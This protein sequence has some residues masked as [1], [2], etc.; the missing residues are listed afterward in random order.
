MQRILSQYAGPGWASRLGQYQ[1]A[2]HQ[3]VLS[4]HDAR[5]CKLRGAAGPSEQHL[6]G[7]MC[8]CQSG[9]KAGTEAVGIGVNFTLRPGFAVSS[10]EPAA[11]LDKASG[12]SGGGAATKRRSATP[13]LGFGDN[14]PLCASPIRPQG[15]QGMD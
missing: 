8:Q 3:A 5:R 9:D 4:L 13:A 7:V 12:D 10:G 11:E 6:V 2:A 1:R 15:W 14:E